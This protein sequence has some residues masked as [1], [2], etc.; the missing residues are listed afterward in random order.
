MNR[1]QCAG[2]ALVAAVALLSAITVANTQQPGTRIRAQIEKADGD[3]F[4]L[5]TREGATISAKLADNARVTALTKGSLDDIKPDTWIGV[6]GI[7]KSDGSIEAFSIHI[8]PAALRGQ[9]E[10]ERPW[11]AKPG[12]TMLNT[13]FQSAVASTDGHSLTVKNKDGEKKIVIGSATVIAKA[14]PAEAGEVKP[15][16]QIIVFGFDKQPDGSVLIKSMYVG[17]GVTP[18][19]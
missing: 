15:G 8:P 2:R 12:S 11:D 3:V 9:G 1:F 5:K 17:R 18:A 10:G 19:M 4:T 7:P 16:A 14:V 13:Y 6:A